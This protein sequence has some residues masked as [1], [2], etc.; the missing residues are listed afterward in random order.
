MIYKRWKSEK[1]EEEDEEEE[2]GEEEE[3]E[4]EE[5][6]KKKKKREEKQEEEE[7]RKRR[8]RQRKKKIL[9]SRRSGHRHFQKQVPVSRLE[10]TQGPCLA[11]IRAGSLPAV[12][13]T[14]LGNHVYVPV[15]RW[16][17]LEIEP[18]TFHMSAKPSID[19]A[20]AHPI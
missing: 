14:P 1:E 9:Y 5:E 8:K 20:A 10:P 15:I 4:E 6:K 3:E 13:V 17:G 12:P 19:C 11:D 18:F 16:V 2:E 7:R